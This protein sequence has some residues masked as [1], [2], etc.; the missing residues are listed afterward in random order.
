MQIREKIYALVVDLKAGL[1]MIESDWSINP[2]IVG[3]IDTNGEAIGV[4]TI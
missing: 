3:S 2:V 4:S 1:K